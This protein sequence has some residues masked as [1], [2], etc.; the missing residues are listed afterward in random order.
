MRIRLLRHATLVIQ[1]GDTRLLIDPMLDPPGAQPPVAETPNPRPNPL[2]PLPVDPLEAV[3]GVSAILV[4]HL[5]GDHFDR[6]A[7]GVV[8]RDRP[9]LCQP[10]DQMMFVRAGLQATVVNEPV[11]IGGVRVSRTTGQH[12]TGAIGQEMGDSSGYV[13]AAD[14]EP[15]L[16]VAGDTVWCPE[17]EEAIA[18]H[19][20]AVI[21]VNAGA[22]RFI[23]GDPITMDVPDVV[24]T[25]N[26][27]PD[28]VIVAVHMEAM[29]HCGLGRA[30]L[31]TAI[32]AAGLAG[33]VATPADGET[34]EL[35]YS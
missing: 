27:A 26:A 17:V 29:N 18:T 14:G 8:P 32:D 33:R 20:P 31:R 7:L 19:D 34:L 2:V 21:V 10:R 1:I 11:E 5:H 6:T 3:A 9:I 23:Q 4:T 22:A 15:T 28:A 16:Y 35:S 30:G 12:G 24:A 25:C 13:I